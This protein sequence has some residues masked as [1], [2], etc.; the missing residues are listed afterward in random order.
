MQII[1]ISHTKH[2]TWE[3]VIQWRLIL[4]ECSPELFYIQGSKHI[5]ADAISRLDI[6][7]TP[8]PVK[9]SIEFVNE[10]YGLEDEDILHPTDYRT[11]V[12]HQKKDKELKKMIQTSKDY[13]IQNIYGVNDKNSLNYGNRKIVI[14][15]QLEK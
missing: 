6:V 12:H 2:F 3:K 11:I 8:N 5:A 7:D 10:Y 1:R 13:S 4:E 14:S 9:N 15:K